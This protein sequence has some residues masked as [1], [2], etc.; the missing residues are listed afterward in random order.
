MKHSV[1]FTLTEKYKEGIFVLFSMQNSFFTL[2][3]FLLLREKIYTD[4]YKMYQ[5]LLN[6]DRYFLLIIDGTKSMDDPFPIN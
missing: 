3:T 6:T 1:K 4:F 5:Y 2:V